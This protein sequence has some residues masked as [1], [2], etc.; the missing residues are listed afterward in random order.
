ME[1]KECI[2]DGTM[3]T[4]ELIFDMK[5]MFRDSS[6]KRKFLV[7]LIIPRNMYFVCFGHCNKYEQYAYFR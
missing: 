4:K 5:N 2:K 3:I 7:F 6:R 1:F